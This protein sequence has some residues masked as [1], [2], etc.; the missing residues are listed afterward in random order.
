MSLHQDRNERDF[1]APIVSVSLGM[2]AVFLFGGEERSASAARVTL[3]HGD[4]VVWGGIDRLRYQ[5]IL[6]LK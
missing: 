1:S 2:S 3:H 5:G 4:V 6:P